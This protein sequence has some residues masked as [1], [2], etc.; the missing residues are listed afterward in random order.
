ME[1]AQGSTGGEG[2]EGRVAT[3]PRD[4]CTPFELS[5]TGPRLRSGSVCVCETESQRK[6]VRKGEKQLKQ[7]GSLHSDTH[8]S[9]EYIQ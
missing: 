3:L 8:E 1:G 4:F 5:N 2:K 9:S 7:H 6:S